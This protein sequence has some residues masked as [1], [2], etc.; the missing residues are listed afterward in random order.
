VGTPGT[1]LISEV[2]SLKRFLGLEE[3]ESS[4]STSCE[5][6]RF[7]KRGKRSFLEDGESKESMASW[8]VEESE[9]SETVIKEEF[10]EG[11]SG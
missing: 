2:V 1:I 8:E 9:I 3:E 5:R 11:I 10:S 4:L 7:L 6:E